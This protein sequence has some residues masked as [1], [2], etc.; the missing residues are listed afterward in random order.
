MQKLAVFLASLLI[1]IS[2]HSQTSIN[3]VGSDDNVAISSFD[4]VAFFTQKEAVTGKS[5]FSHTHLGAKWLFSSA[6]VETEK[7]LLEVQLMIRGRCFC[8]SRLSRLYWL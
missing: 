5:E 1:S 8:I 6:D 3:V 7:S 4:A 2:S